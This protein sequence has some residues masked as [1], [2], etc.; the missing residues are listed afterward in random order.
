MGNTLTHTQDKMKEEKKF[1][2]NFI[3]KL[4]PKSRLALLSRGRCYYDHNFLRIFGKKLAFFLNTHVMIKYFSKLSFVFSQKRQF[5]AKFFCENILKIIT[6]VP[7][8]ELQGQ[9]PKG[10]ALRRR[11]VQGKRSPRMDAL[12]YEG[13]V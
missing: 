9:L 2:V 8:G 13:K 11:N 3:H 4:E 12:N 10:I 6:S 7:G 1:Q 5:F